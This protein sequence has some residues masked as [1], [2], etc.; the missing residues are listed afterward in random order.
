MDAYSLVREAGINPTTHQLINTCKLSYVPEKE[1]SCYESSLRFGGGRVT[2]TGC[3]DSFPEKVTMGLR[4][5]GW[6]RIQEGKGQEKSISGRGNNTCKDSVGGKNMV[7]VTGVFAIH[8][9]PQNPLSFKL[10]NSKRK[11]SRVKSAPL[12]PKWLK[13]WYF[14]KIMR[15]VG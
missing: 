13:Q 3:R 7:S 15:K 12:L 8:R 1:V 9:S 4:S 11:I 14:L 2:S 5:K 6:N 10:K